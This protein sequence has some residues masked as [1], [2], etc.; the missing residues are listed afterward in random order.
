MLHD[1]NLVYSVI[2]LSAGLLALGLVGK[3]FEKA[4]RIQF[5]FICGLLRTIIVAIVLYLEAAQFDVSREIGSKLLSNSTLFIAI[6]SF[7]SQKAL[8]NI[9]GGIS[10]SLSKPL[11][12]GQK[13]SIY[14]NNALLAE[15]IVTEMS[16]RHIV[17]RKYDGKSCILPNSIVDGAVII[18]DNYEDGCGK[19]FEVIIDKFADTTKAIDIIKNALLMCDGVADKNPE[20]LVSK[21]DENTKTLKFTLWTNDLDSSYVVSSILRDKL[22]IGFNLENIKVYKIC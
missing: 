21:I 10:I 2:V 15:G 11:E 22:N 14:N 6:I 19:Y 16:A 4:T 17:I 5:K 8:S 7:I 3:A 12:I 20:I 9:I 13:V 1:I 18:N